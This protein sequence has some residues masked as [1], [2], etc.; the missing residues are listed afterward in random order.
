[1]ELQSLGND[2]QKLSK[3][4]FIS[5]VFYFILQLKVHVTIPLRGTIHNNCS[6]T[7]C[8]IF[9][10][11]CSISNVFKSWQGN[12]SC[13]VSR[14]ATG[15]TKYPIQWRPVVFSLWVSNWGINL[16]TILYPVPQLTMGTAVAPFLSNT[17]MTRTEGNCIYVYYWQ[18]MCHYTVLQ[19]LGRYS[20]YAT[21]CT[22]ARLQSD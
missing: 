20:D 15:P 17:F 21:G 7:F 10:A 13:K 18:T 19:Q 16:T 22:V 12:G 14:M 4:H 1:M 3:I 9:A 8:I 2:A 5:Q 11:T 6:G